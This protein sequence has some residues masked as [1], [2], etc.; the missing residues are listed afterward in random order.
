MKTGAFQ[1]CPVPIAYISISALYVKGKAA[2]NDTDAHG[3]GDESHS[4]ESENIGPAHPRELSS[5]WSRK[6]AKTDLPRRF[7]TVPSKRRLIPEICAQLKHQMHSQHL[8]CRDCQTNGGKRPQ[9][10]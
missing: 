1:E 6:S 4:D 9:S 2:M 8:W 3:E 10:R 7:T 5:L